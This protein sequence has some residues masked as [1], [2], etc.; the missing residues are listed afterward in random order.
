MHRIYIYIYIYC[1]RLDSQYS[2]LAKIYM[3]IVPH[4][5]ISGRIIQKLL[6]TVLDTPL[7][8]TQH[9]MVLI[10]SKVEQSR[11]RVVAIENGDF[12][13]FSITVDKFT[14]IFIYN[15]SVRTQDIVLRTCQ[16]RW[17]IEM[18]DQRV[19]EIRAS[20]TIWSWYIYIYL[21]M[22]VWVCVCVCVC[23]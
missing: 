12:G 15:N 14:Y 2:K 20:S 17:M 23:V 21:Y 8:N 3:N 19:M 5:S 18:N 4:G 13:S 22:C 10:K 7:L 9:Y 11:E 6:K 1:I 16:K